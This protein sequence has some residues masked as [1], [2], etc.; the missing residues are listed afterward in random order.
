MPEIKLVHVTFNIC[1]SLQ[2]QSIPQCGNLDL[3][4]PTFKVVYTICTSFY[5]AQPCQMAVI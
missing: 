3:E 1:S 2:I 5:Y 4:M